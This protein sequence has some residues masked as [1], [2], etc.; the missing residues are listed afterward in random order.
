MTQTQTQTATAPITINRKDKFKPRADAGLL[1]RLIQEAW[2]QYQD[3]IADASAQA[4]VAER[5]ARHFETLIPSSDFE[6]LE[7]YEVVAYHDHC[8]VRV[9]DNNTEDVAK[10]REA[11]GIQLPRK[12]PVLGSGGYC[13]PSLV[14]CEPEWGK[15][16]LRELDSYFASLLTAR[17]AY[18]AEYKASGLFPQQHKAV[19]GGYPTWGEIEDAFPVLGG[20]LK[21]QRAASAAEVETAVIAEVA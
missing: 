3:S 11:F 17:K 4:K 16:P 2:G 12:V 18:Q 9:Y 13:Y 8:K 7:R 10:Y 19:T 21:R 5:I 1:S 20:F 15:S 14:A 6:V